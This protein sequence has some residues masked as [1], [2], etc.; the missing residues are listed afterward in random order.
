MV[1]TGP[2]HEPGA[3]FLLNICTGFGSRMLLGCQQVTIY[4]F[5]ETSKR[6]D[7]KQVATISHVSHFDNPMGFHIIYCLTNMYIAYYYFDPPLFYKQLFMLS[8]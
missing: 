2:K 6:F 7:E 8:N 1:F 3:N 4:R 5:E